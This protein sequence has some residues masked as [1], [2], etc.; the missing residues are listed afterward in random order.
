MGSIR[1]ISTAVV[2]FGLFAGAVAGA[3]TPVPGGGKTELRAGGTKAPVGGD[4]RAVAG[5]SVP[6]TG[7][8]K[9]PFTDLIES[10]FTSRGKFFYQA[11]FQNVGE[12]TSSR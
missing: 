10:V 8:P 7:V 5:L 1:R 12:R 11:W 3:Q 2:V 9:R 4:K 6:Y